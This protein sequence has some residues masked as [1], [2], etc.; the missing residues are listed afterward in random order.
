MATHQIDSIEDYFRYLEENPSEVEALSKDFLIGV[1]RFF[2]DPEASEVFSEKVFSALINDKRPGS[3]LRIWV[4]GCSTGEEA[5][6]IAIQ[7]VEYMEKVNV[8]QGFQ[9]FGT[10]LDPTAIDRARLG[11]P[12]KHYSRYIRRAPGAFLR[13][14]RKRV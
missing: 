8:R 10:H 7:L 6:S 9:I 12:G 14:I 3:I 4:P 5:V 13:K 1:T 11:I 2:R